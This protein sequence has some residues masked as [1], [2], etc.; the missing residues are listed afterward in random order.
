MAR[1]EEG[2]HLFHSQLK[3]ED[4][5]TVSTTSASPFV[6][7][8]DESAPSAIPFAV[9][10]TV[11]PSSPAEQAGLKPGDK[12][13]VF[14]G[15]RGEVGR[16]GLLSRVSNVVQ[17]SEGR[18]VRVEVQ[19][20]GE[21]GLEVVRMVLTPRSGWG[22]RGLLGCEFRLYLSVLVGPQC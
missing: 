11:A 5:V 7:N 3:P 16:E 1:I 6:T 17:G 15:V 21:S 22:G 19:R 10:N 8:G 20:A 2:L 4:L 12:I 18:E 14:G 9:V 13:T